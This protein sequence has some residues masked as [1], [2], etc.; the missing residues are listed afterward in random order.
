MRP[1]DLLAQRWPLLAARLSELPPTA[2]FRVEETGR[3]RRLMLGSHSLLGTDP[4]RDAARWADKVL[5]GTAR[6]GR[7]PQR[8]HLMGHGVGWELRHLFEH[9][10]GRILLHVMDLAQFR[11]LLD[12]WACPELLTD[13]RLDI[14]WDL[15]S[16]VGRAEPGDAVVE[17]PFARRHQP[18]EICARRAVLGL[19]RSAALRLRVLVVEP[20]YGGSLPMARSAAQALREL[21]HEVRSLDVEQLAGAREAFQNF[22]DRHPGASV[23]AAEFTRLLGRMLVVEARAFSPDLVIGL[24]QSPFTPEAA[25]E[26]RKAGVRSAFWFVEDWETLDYWR[27]LHGHFDLFLPIQR[28]SFSKALAEH[29]NS[30]VRYLPTCADPSSSRPEPWLEGAVPRLSF[31][32]AGYHNRERVFLQLLDLPLRIWGSDWRPGGPLAKR[33]ENGGRRTTAV[34]NRRIFSNSQVNLNLHS[35]GYHDGIRQDGDFVNP[36][37]FEILACGGFQLVDRRSLM[38]GLLEPGRD[39]ACFSTVEELRQCAAHFLAHEEERRRMA[40][41][42][43][44]TVLALHTYRHRMAQLLELF[45]IEQEDAFPH[46]LKRHSVDEEWGDAELSAWMATLPAEAPRDLDGLAAWLGQG[47]AELQ[48][49]ALTILYMHELRQWARSKGVEQLLEQ[50]RHG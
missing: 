43:R 38:E 17:W 49:P 1:F 4:G 34:E 32:G 29:S 48:G 8:L 21:G 31:V 22:A 47:G 9:G 11:F 50:A 42:G 44:R 25:Q 3:G 19:L 26:L 12:H 20:L 16:C 39:M 10:V 33:L 35:S 28:G 37:T 14:V 41:E 30:P 7:A 40:Q 23:L 27:G 6:D 45:L 46:A 15:R 5:E 24:A 2:M 13:D 36:R 18:E